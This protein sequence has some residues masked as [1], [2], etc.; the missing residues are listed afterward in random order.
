TLQ[1][2]PARDPVSGGEL[3]VTELASQDSGITIRGHF[4]IP[5]YARLDEEQSRFLETF[6]R[7]RGMFNA[8]E[9]ELGISYP[10]VKS[11][12]ESLL[13][14]LDL[15]PIESKPA[16]KVSAKEADARRTA[17]LDRLSSGEITAEEA[18]QE[19]RHGAAR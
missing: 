5:L 6:L 4:A 17:I 16:D 19:I 18:K 2:I 13:T 10:T 3:H 1:K 15:S 12:L 11:R 7:C 14:A 8:V 9:R